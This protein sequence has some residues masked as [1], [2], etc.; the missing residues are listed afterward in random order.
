MKILKMVHIKKNFLKEKK[1]TPVALT[2]NMR[3]TFTWFDV[4]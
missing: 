3:A 2:I 4:V 1:K